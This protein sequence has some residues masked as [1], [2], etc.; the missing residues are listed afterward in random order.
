MKYNGLNKEQVKQSINKYG[1]NELDK[2]KRITILTKIIG[3]FKEP[4]FLLLFITAIIY[5]V[6]GETRDGIIMIISV[7]FM[8]IIE[9]IQEWKMDKAIE[10]LNTIT[11]LNVTVIR[12]SK[13]QKISSKDIVV[14]D[15]V[16]LKEGDYVCADGKILECSGL[17]VNESA[18][19]GESDIIY[20]EIGEDNNHFKKNICYAGTNIVNGSAIIEIF[21][22]GSNTT[23][24]KI[25]K[26]LNNIVK[27]LTPLEHKIKKIIV[28][29]T[30]FSFSFFVLVFLANVYV[31]NGLIPAIISSLTIAMATIPEE[32]P[33]ILTVFLA[34]GSLSLAK[35]KTLVRNLES[36]QTLGSVNVLCTDKTGTLTE[37]KM[38]VKD[39]Y[40]YDNVVLSSLLS[41]SIHPYDPMEIAIQNYGIKLGHRLDDVYNHKLNKEYIFNNKDKMM[42]NIWDDT[43]YVKGAYESVLSLC[44]NIDKSAIIE[45][46]AY[47][48]SKGYRVIAVAYKR[49]EEIKDNLNDYTLNFSG[50][51]ALIDPPR[52]GVKEAIKESISAGVRVIIITGDNGAT[53]LSLANNLGIC[54]NNLVLTGKELESTSDDELKELVKTTN[55]YARVYPD[56]KKRIVSALKSNGDV[57]A[58]TGDGIND[59]TALKISDIGIAMGR[60]TNV[61]K[62]SSD[63]ILVDDNFTTIVKAIKNGRTI[64]NNITKAIAYIFVVHIPIAVLSL[65]VPIL[66]LDNLLLP[67]HIVLMEFIIDPTSS[68]I[69]QRLKPDKDIMNNPPHKESDPL[70]PN[71]LLMS[72][73]LQGIVITIICLFTYINYYFNVD[74]RYATT[75][76]F[77]TLVL[78][79]ILSSLVLESNDFMYKNVINNMKDK[80]IILINLAIILVLLSVVYLPEFHDIVN[81]TSISLID[82]IIVIFNSLLCTVPFDIFKIKSHKVKNML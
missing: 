35:D 80:V 22:V 41:S 71:S 66:R 79:N 6:L 30:I 64:Y 4:M 48:T 31:G 69:F 44:L 10:A 5:F 53:A 27:T 46:A 42:G 82:L 20:K 37:N 61:A 47:L 58:M 2:T 3:I 12:D 74:Q 50:L 18:L 8:C 63:M 19:T 9:I 49:I 16:V 14:G 70:I 25:G 17:G 26:S 13:E 11:S 28:Y 59:A 57:V 51:L 60:G 38:E 43:L 7:L 23:Y 54:S 21:A 65:I 24:G 1:K 62:E 39:I 33:V 72:S 78:S 34:M 56:H 29:C 36:V 68:V 52:Y 32:I 55:I 77:I 45:K 75:C 81:T 76:A 73:I 15:I 67:I 40:D